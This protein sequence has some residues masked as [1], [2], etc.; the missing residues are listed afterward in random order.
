MA[1]ARPPAYITG[2]SSVPVT[3]MTGPPAPADPAALLL[4]AAQAAK[5]A[6]CGCDRRCAAVQA[7]ELINPSLASS[8]TGQRYPCL[9]CAVCWLAEALS[10]AQEAGLVADGA[11]CP[12]GSA[13]PRPGWPPLPGDYTVLRYGAPVA[14]C[15]LGDSQL[16][17]AVAAQAGAEVAS[18]RRPGPRAG[19]GAGRTGRL[20]PA[21]R[22]F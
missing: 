1:P 7:R 10:L 16:A 5:C 6:A 19:D 12:A 18:A 15:T 4:E 9:G 8:L 21:A 22:D 14:V 3:I 17:A 13:V 2:M 20:A 11:S